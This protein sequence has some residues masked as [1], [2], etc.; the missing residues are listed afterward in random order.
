MKDKNRQGMC[1]RCSRMKLAKY[2]AGLELDIN[3]HRSNYKYC[4]KYD[5]Y[6]LSVARNC[7]GSE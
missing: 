7:L 1:A 4:L 5:N 2:L 3:D 6:C